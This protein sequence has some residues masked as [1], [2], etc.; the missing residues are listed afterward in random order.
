MPSRFS[1]N[2]LLLGMKNDL[3]QVV[4]PCLIKLKSYE[5]LKYIDF[6]WE[7]GIKHIERLSSLSEMPEYWGQNGSS[8]KKNKGGYE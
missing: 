6:V 2:S 8:V 5:S 4:S 3:C 1:L 7:S